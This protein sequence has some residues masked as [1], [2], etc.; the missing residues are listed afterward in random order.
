MCCGVV[1]KVESIGGIDRLRSPSMEPTTCP[2]LEE[3]PASSQ[4]QTE[5]F[6]P[7]HSLQPRQYRLLETDF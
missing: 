6:N 7:Q 2:P 3:Q 4:L 1:R 5:E